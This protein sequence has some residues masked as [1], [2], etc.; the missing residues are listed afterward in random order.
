MLRALRILTLI[1]VLFCALNVGEDA[2]AADGPAATELVSAADTGGDETP[3][4]PEA[5]A[6]AVHHHCPIADGLSGLPALAASM[7]DTGLL[8]A[9]AIAAL[10]S[11][12]QAPPID[13][14]LA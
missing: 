1:A 11:L 5:A 2:Y 3:A 6:H 8:F 10:A 12:S 9:P 7:T 4:S 14:P 13:P